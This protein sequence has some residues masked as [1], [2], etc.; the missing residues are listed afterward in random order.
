MKYIVFENNSVKFFTSLDPNSSDSAIVLGENSVVK[1]VEDDY[2]IESKILT[3]VNDEIVSV[4]EDL[5]ALVAANALP[6]LRSER[7]NRL[8]ETDVWGLQDYPATS[9]Q[10]IYR[11]ALRDITD[12]YSSLDDVVWPTKP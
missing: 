9:E 1:E 6:M 10:L 8:R 4:D 3:L 5:N 2:T 11:Q 12:T 7:D